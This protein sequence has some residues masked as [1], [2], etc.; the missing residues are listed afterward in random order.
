MIV[1]Y[2]VDFLSFILS[3]RPY[4]IVTQVLHF[5]ELSKNES[6]EPNDSCSKSKSKVLSD[7]SLEGQKQTPASQEQQV[8][9]PED[10]SSLLLILLPVRYLMTDVYSV[11]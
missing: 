3:E 11:G 1:D 10:F 7:S 8:R 9:L 2:F 6:K 4:V 5:N